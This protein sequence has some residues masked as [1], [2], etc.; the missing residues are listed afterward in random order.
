MSREFNRFMI[1]LVSLQSLRQ[2]AM[3]AIGRDLMAMVTGPEAGDNQTTVAGWMEPA[4]EPP[5]TEWGWPN[6]IGGCHCPEPTVAA[7]VPVV[8]LAPSKWSMQA[9][10][11][12][13]ALS[14]QGHQHTTSPT[15]SRPLHGTD[16]AAKAV[17]LQTRRWDPQAL[18]PQSLK[19]SEVRNEVAMKCMSLLESYRSGNL[20]ERDEA[21]PTL[22]AGGAAYSS[23]NPGPG[24]DNIAA[25]NGSRGIFDALDESR[26]ATPDRHPTVTQ[27]A[28]PPLSNMSRYLLSRSPIPEVQFHNHLLGVTPTRLPQDEGC[29]HDRASGHESP[30]DSNASLLPTLMSSPIQVENCSPS[31]Q[32]PASQTSGQSN[33]GSLAQRL[34]SRVSKC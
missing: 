8:P 12:A 18:D 19:D 15:A 10:D 27:A 6:L 32:P 16:K 14:S 7:Q 17:V 31:P 24:V 29:R 33:H 26:A 34:L 28:T 21:H 25:H 23:Y 30:P 5:P 20:N 22:A 2:A 11:R 4:W 13:A 3:Q 1:I 9:R